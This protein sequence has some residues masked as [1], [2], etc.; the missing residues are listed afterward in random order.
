MFLL[1]TRVLPRGGGVSK[2]VSIWDETNQLRSASDLFAAIQ[3]RNV[4]LVTHGF[5]VDQFDGEAHL[6]GWASGLSLASTTILGILWPGDSRWIPKVDYV[7]EGNE[8]IASGD[9]L[10]DFINHNFGGAISLSFA[11]HSLGARMVLE[12]ING[13]SRDVR[14]LLLMAGAIDNN[15]LSAEYSTAAKKIKSISILAS[16]EDEVLKWAFPAGNF[17]GGLLSRGVPYVHEA[18]GREGPCIPYTPNLQP[19]WQIPDSWN[20]GHGDYLPSST[21]APVPPVVAFPGNAPDVKGAWSAAFMS[22]R[23]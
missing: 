12:T 2:A 21:V 20:Y 5:S 6:A 14:A 7:V 11:S 13:L 22:G 17:I 16:R 19:G 3:G 1:S 23:F 4:L 8:A 10:A 9:L 15:C 18:L